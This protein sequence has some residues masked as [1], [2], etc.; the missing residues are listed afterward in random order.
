MKQHLSKL[1]SRRLLLLSLVIL[2]LLQACGGSGVE[3][4][5]SQSSGGNNGSPDGT[6]TGGEITEPE[7]GGPT[8]ETPP[9]TSVSNLD[10]L[11]VAASRFLA[12]ATRPPRRGGLAFSGSGNLRPDRR[13]NSRTEVQ[14]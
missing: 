11:D 10:P 13:F 8:G 1:S 6:P 12:Q 9:Q 7:N 4:G 2:P 14:S 3:V 5:G